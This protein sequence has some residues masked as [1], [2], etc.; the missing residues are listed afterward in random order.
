MFPAFRKIKNK[1]F[2]RFVE[3]AILPAF[4]ILA[5]KSVTMIIYIVIYN[6]NFYIQDNSIQL[7]SFNDFLMANDYSNIITF[8]VVLSFSL[9]LLVKGF[10]FHNTH[11][12]PKLSSWL[13]N[14]ELSF[15]I[16]GSYELYLKLIVWTIFLWFITLIISIHYFLG[17]TSSWVFYSS[18]FFTILTTVLTMVD[19]ERDYHLF[20]LSKY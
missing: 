10:L 14:N 8:L 4:V 16:M 6:L 18:V 19:V 7:T 15:L 12:S 5:V 1:M 20:R 3:D 11:I 17:I 2:F 13:H 9:W